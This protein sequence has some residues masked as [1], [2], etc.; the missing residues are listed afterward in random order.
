MFY[1]VKLFVLST[2]MI[3][4]MVIL[5]G[6]LVVVGLVLPRLQT[7]LQFPSTIPIG[8]IAQK[9]AEVFGLAFLMMA[10]LHWVSLRWR[11]FT[12]TVGVGI[13]GM[14]FGYGMLLTTRGGSI[15][16]AIYCPWT[17]PMMA[18]ARPPVN[19]APLIW[20]SVMSGIGLSAVGCWRFSQRDVE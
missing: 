8:Q 7:D 17:F 12:V 20:I 14:V 9:F 6:G 13:I 15:G 19:V 5:V 11:S 1:A 3:M 10:I 2:M 4:S 18:L 16:F